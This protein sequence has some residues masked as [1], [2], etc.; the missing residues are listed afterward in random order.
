MREKDGMESECN[1][2]GW[3][4]RP[5]LEGESARGR[6]VLA[7]P[8]KAPPMA[9]GAPLAEPAFAKLLL[10]RLVRPARRFPTDLA[11]S[12]VRGRVSQCALR[13][14]AWSS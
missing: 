8:A 1:I 4:G 14:A 12:D 5:G 6:T 11:G 13:T 7:P 2:T 9:V 3:L 10:R